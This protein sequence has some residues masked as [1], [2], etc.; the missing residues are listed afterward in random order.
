MPLCSTSA[1]CVYVYFL[2]S[3]QDF[4][5]TPRFTSYPLSAMLHLNL[6]RQTSHRNQTGRYLSL[7]PTTETFQHTSAD[8]RVYG[9]QFL[10]IIFGLFDHYSYGILLLF[11]SNTHA[12]VH[13]MLIFCRHFAH[14]PQTAFSVPA[15]LFE[16]S[17]STSRSPFLSDCSAYQFIRYSNAWRYI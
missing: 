17:Q 9:Y 14:H 6:S 7:I 1:D 11:C 16:T 2:Y 12:R 13:T 5:H 4:S 3:N 10:V 8:C 15:D